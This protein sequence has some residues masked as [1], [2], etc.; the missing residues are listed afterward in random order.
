M[1][2]LHEY[3]DHL[4]ADG[5]YYFT[6]DGAMS[7]MSLKQSQFQFQAYR[8]TKKGVIVR[9][10]SG[11]Y[12][13]VS[14]EYRHFGALPPQ[15]IIDP[16]MKHLGQDYYIGL[17]SAASIY[18]ATH[19]SPMSFQVVT[20]KQIRDITL[21]RSKIE[22]HCSKSCASALK[23]QITVPT[24]YFSISS[25]EQTLVDLLRFYEASGYMSNVATVIKDLAPECSEVA[26]TQ[27]VANESTNSVLQRLGY[28][29]ELTGFSNLAFIIGTELARRTMQ[30]IELRPDFHE[31]SGE[32]DLR[33]KLII[34]DSLEIE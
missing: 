6:K 22:F 18:G 10:M 16:L 30:C 17:L 11:F 33:W 24:G 4:L 7:D 29:L 25:K 20:T 14:A 34:N 13:I 5:K 26:L 19:Q 9:L 8:L 2:Y 1:K 27:V 21:S 3:I 28:I 31:K 12:M 15:W 32:K 23:S